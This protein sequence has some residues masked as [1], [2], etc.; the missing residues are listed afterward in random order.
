MYVP[1]SLY[2]LARQVP[3]QFA[4]A[5]A[6]LALLLFSLSFTKESREMPD[7]AGH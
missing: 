4:L 3:L 5:Y 7:V 6:V 1:W 2:G